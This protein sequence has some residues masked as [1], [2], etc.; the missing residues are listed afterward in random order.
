VTSSGRWSGCCPLTCRLRHRITRLAEVSGP[1][2]VALGTDLDGNYQ[3]VLTNYHQLADLTWLLRDRERLA[4]Q[5]WHR[6][7]PA[8]PHRTVN[9][10]HPAASGRAGAPSA[11]PLW[12]AVRAS[13]WPRRASRMPPRPVTTGHDAGHRSEDRRRIPAELVVKVKVD[14]TTDTTPGTLAGSSVQRTLTCRIAGVH[15]VTPGTVE[16]HLIWVPGLSWPTPTGFGEAD[17]AKV[18]WLV[19]RRGGDD[20]GAWLLR[21]YSNRSANSV[22]TVI[23]AGQTTQRYATGSNVIVPEKLVRAVSVRCS[24]AS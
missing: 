6:H 11:G 13:D 4:A 16:P 22:L 15:P 12:Q 7:G 10:P 1:G 17:C 14:S 2:H 3:P 8:E 19:T 23:V 18:S 20:P 21:G 9:A 5:V 24:L